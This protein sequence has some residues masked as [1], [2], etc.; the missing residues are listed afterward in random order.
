MPVAREVRL[1]LKGGSDGCAEGTGV[2]GIGREPEGAAGRAVEPQG[3]GPALPS[4]TD[5]RE[6]ETEGEE[7]RGTDD[8]W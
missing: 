2:A 5:Q 8:R 4:E 7:P 6:A 3:P 1:A